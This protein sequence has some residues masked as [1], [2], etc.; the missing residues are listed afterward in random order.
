MR[1]K[2][3][4]GRPRSR[5]FL[6]PGTPPGSRSDDGRKILCFRKEEEKSGYFERRPEHSVLNKPPLEKNN[7]IGALPIGILPEPN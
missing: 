5:A 4:P 2:S 7:F 6:P 3:L 1:K